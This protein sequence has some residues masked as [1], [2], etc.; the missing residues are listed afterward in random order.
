ML[1][2]GMAACSLAL[3]SLQVGA[4]QQVF[5]AKPMVLIIPFAAGGPVDAVGRTVAQSMSSKLG[6]PVIV[7]NVAGAGGNIG[8]ARLAQSASDGYTDDARVD[9]ADDQS[10]AVCQA[11]LQHRQASTPSAASD[12]VAVVA[13]R[14]RGQS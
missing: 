9:R 1:L 11:R 7:D 12:R 5:P 8:A 14:E 2:A 6:Q 4:Q 10:G 3:P 13:V